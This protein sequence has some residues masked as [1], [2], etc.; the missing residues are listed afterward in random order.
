MLF[1]QKTNVEE[2]DD[3]ALVEVKRF[4]AIA[5]RGNCLTMNRDELQFS[6]KEI[7]RSM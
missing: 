4:R 3:E 6:T 7:C 1:V 2:F 5:A